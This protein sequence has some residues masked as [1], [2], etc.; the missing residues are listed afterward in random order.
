MHFRMEGDL[1][2]NMVFVD[3]HTNFANPTQISSWES[4]Q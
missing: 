4:N 2:S 3:T 1:I